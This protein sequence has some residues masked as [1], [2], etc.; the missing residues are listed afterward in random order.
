MI[1]SRDLELFRDFK[2]LFMKT[3][4]YSDSNIFE[5]VI[6]LSL[7]LRYPS[8]EIIKELDIT[9]KILFAEIQMT[10]DFKIHITE[11]IKKGERITIKFKKEFNYT[12]DEV[13]Y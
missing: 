3:I 8:D 10:S 6:P 12:S 13:P 11:G 5:Y 1:E 9:I 4:L 7:L 2:D